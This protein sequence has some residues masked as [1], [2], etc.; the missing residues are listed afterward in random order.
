[1]GIRTNTSSN[2]STGSGYTS[3]GFA[4]DGYASE[5]N[6]PSPKAPVI[7]KTEPT[8][9]GGSVFSADIL[10][11]EISGPS[12]DNLTVIDVPGIF[13]TPTEGVTTNADMALVRAMVE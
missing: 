9:K 13:R 2:E 1:M 3:D 7:V 8:F 10:K 11:I 12:V 6:S 5:G 4:S